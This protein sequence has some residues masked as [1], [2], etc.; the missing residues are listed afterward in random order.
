M[1]GWNGMMAYIG[2]FKS[3]YGDGVFLFMN[4]AYYVPALPILILN[5]KLSSVRLLFLRVNSSP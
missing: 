2:V 5:I 3:W 4:I 1:A